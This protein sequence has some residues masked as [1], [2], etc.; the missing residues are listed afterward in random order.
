VPTATPGHT[1]GEP[2][3]PRTDLFSFGA[4]LYE[5]ATGRMPFTG[6][7]SAIIFNS[8]LE[9]IPVPPVR[10]NPEIPRKLEEIIDKALEKHRDV[11]YQHAADIRADLKRLKRDT[12]SGR[13]SV[14]ASGVAPDASASVST[15]DSSP[16]PS[17]AHAS[18]SSSVAAVARQH[19]VGAAAISVIVLALVAAAS[20]GVYALLH[21]APAV[22]FQNFDVTQITNTGSAVETAISPDGKFLLT[23]Q[24]D[25]NEDSLWLRD[26]ASGSDTQVVPPSG[27][28]LASPAFS[29]NGSYIYFRR[30]SPGAITYDLFRAPLFGGTPEVVARDVAANV[31]SSPDGKNIVY[32]RAN[33]P[34]LGKWSLFEAQADGSDEKLLLIGAQGHVPL[35]LA[36]SPDETRI[37][38]S[39]FT[40]IEMFDLATQKMSA[41]TGTASSRWCPSF[42]WAPD[43]RS[44][45]LDYHIGA[46]IGFQIGAIS[47]PEGEFR[48]I[49]N[50]ANAYESL[51][52]SADG[53]ALAVVQRES[54]QEIDL[55]PASGAGPFL[56]VPGIPPKTALTSFNWTSDGQLLL[57]QGHQLTRRRTDGTAAVALLSDSN[58]LVKDVIP[59]GDNRTIAITWNGHDKS[60]GWPLWRANADGSGA[61]LLVENA[62]TVWGCSS[63][64]KWL[65]FTRGGTREL[66][67]IPVTGGKPEPLPDFEIPDTVHESEALSPDGS[68][69]ALFVGQEDP[70]THAHSSKIVLVTARSHGKSAAY[71]IV[72]DPH[73]TLPASY[74]PSRGN[75]HFTPDGKAIA[76]VIEDKGVDNIWVQ[77]LDGSKGRQITHFDSQRIHDFHWSPD[78]SRLAVDRLNRS[79]D[80]IL[81]RDIG[82]SQK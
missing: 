28:Q 24:S 66:Q 57:A 81:L 31:A 78:G 22:P 14:A 9:K 46:S 62:G 75:I 26:I 77:P 67:R 27:Q 59:C 4:V 47:F 80:V 3:D 7:T 68:T 42:A 49:T 71:S 34:A 76:L 6:N 8:I 52:L 55:M 51:S 21:R 11:R 73:C 29:P 58:A 23:V 54:S 74:G 19:K 32:A 36:W 70:E 56:V 2:L 38:A 40:G 82:P 45:F 37:A 64:S 25:K 79:G 43:S 69:L 30:L 60:Q 61:A 20:Y 35:Y 48:G 44:I 17:A 10:L 13:S 33:S 72:L 50:D 63:D 65:Y 18:G 53:K 16:A 12:D 5:M 39:F 41:F 15:A 1:R